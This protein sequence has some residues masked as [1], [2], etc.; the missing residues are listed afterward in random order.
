MCYLV[1]PHYFLSERKLI[2][3]VF[4]HQ[5]ISAGLLAFVG[6]G[7]TVFYL[8]RQIRQSDRHNEDRRQ[9]RETEK[10]IQAQGIAL[11]VRPSLMI[12][13]MTIAD[14]IKII[15]E[16]ASNPNLQTVQVPDPILSQIGH[17]WLMGSPGGHTLQLV[18]ALEADARIVDEITNC[19]NDSAT[20]PR[21]IAL[22]IKKRVAF[23]KAIQ[24]DLTDAQAG[25][26]VLLNA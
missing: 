15:R 14:Q 9:E 2:D 6:A 25:I 26:K 11:L 20:N 17:L 7:M 5:T 12:L 3:W 21:K 18:S 1:Q 24:K 13:S 16:D 10:L 22:M 4:E 8:S 19:M 23:L